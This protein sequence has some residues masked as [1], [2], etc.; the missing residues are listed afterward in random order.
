MM[1]EMTNEDIQALEYILS[2]HTA[3]SNDVVVMQNFMVKFIDNKTNICKGCPAQIR[4]A[5][6]RI[7]L[8]AQANHDKIYAQPE[9]GMC[10]V[11]GKEVE[12][13]RRTYCS[14]ECKKIKKRK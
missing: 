4:F 11:C 10:P 9:E 3:S 14:D 1:R 2:L 13:K 6:N 8:W 7:K 5:F 12:D